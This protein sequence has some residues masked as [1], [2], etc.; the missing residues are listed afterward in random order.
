MLYSACAKQICNNRSYFSTFIACKGS[1]QVRNNDTIESLG[2]GNVRVESLEHYIKHSIM[3]SD[4]WYA[5]DIMYSL[6]LVPRARRRNF[7]VIIELNDQN[8]GNGLMQ[9]L[10]K[11][12]CNVRLVGMETPY[13]FYGEVLRVRTTKRA[14]SALPRAQTCDTRALDTAVRQY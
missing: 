11:P 3:L 2:V 1:V 12:S 8:L 4:V 7:K 5:L 9:L 10:H 13:G 6:N 14:Q